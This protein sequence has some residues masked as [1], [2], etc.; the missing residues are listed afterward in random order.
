MA[1]NRGLL[2]KILTGI[3]KKEPFDPVIKVN[4]KRLKIRI[5][6]SLIEIVPV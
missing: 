1:E 5:R 3:V 4:N 2:K 6:F